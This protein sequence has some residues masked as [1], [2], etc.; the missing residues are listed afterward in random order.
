MVGWY[1]EDYISGS[2]TTV[3]RESCRGR[4]D[5]DTPD[6]QIWQQH[7]LQ[8]NQGKHRAIY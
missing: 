2:W 3:D 4:M 7:Y 8:Q 5:G 1:M 6:G